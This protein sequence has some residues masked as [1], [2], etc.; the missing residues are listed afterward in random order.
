MGQGLPTLCRERVS[1]S[2]YCQDWQKA[3]RFGMNLATLIGFAT[4][5]ELSP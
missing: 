5:F 3:A 1:L 4:T 2:C